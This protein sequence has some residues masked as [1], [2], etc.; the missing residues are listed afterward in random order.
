MR[1]SESGNADYRKRSRGGAQ[2][3]RCALQIKTSSARRLHWWGAPGG[4]GGDEVIELAHVG[5]H[6]DLTFPEWAR[7]PT[8]P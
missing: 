5:T 6:D 7:L 8:H 3:W 1:V 4:P 2:A